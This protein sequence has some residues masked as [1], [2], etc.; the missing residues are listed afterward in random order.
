MKK[1]IV[2]I[3]LLLA[4]PS[5]RA[6]TFDEW[7]RQKKTQIKYLLQQ[8]VANEVYVEFLQKGYT[9]AESGLK[10]I[11]YIKEGDFNLHHDFFNSLNRVNPKIK[12]FPKVSGIISF[13]LQIVRE[14]KSTMRKIGTSVWFTPAET[15]YLR[16]VFDHLL[17]ECTE[18]ISELLT[19]IT[20]GEKGSDG[21]QMKDDE[22]IK[23]IDGIYEDMQDKLSFSKSFSS[24]AL[25]FATQRSREKTD[26]EV[27]K[28]VNGISR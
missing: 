10:T 16:N 17:G 26:I 14:V 15:S 25:L 22:R 7:F 5:L 19:V 12:N 21:Y 3:S 4:V 20:S 18:N 9:I 6:Q 13:Q 1:I 24:E 2:F 11:N 23:R 8:I 28:K 27:S